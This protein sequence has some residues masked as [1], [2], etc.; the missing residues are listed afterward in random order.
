MKMIYKVLL[1]TPVVFMIPLVIQHVHYTMIIF[2]FEENCRENSTQNNT[3]KK[4]CI[5][6]GGPPQEPLLE[7]WFGQTSF[8]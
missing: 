4:L 7:K 6:P 3:P 2:E 8:L 1:L 5:W